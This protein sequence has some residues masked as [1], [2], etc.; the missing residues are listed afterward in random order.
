[1][2]TVTNRPIISFVK[3]VLEMFKNLWYT[4]TEISNFN[5]FYIKKQTKQKKN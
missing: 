4:H 5:K 2:I 1:M 3:N